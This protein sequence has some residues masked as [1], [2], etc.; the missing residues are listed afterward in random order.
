MTKN[1]PLY[2]DYNS[3]TPLDSRVLEAMIPHMTTYFGNPA[4]QLHAYGW[5]ASL[6]VQKATEQTTKLIHAIP[7][8]IVWNSGATEGNNSV[9]WGVVKTLK[10][11]NPRDKI[12]FITTEIEHASVLKTFEYLKLHENIEYTVLPVNSLGFVSI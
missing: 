3:T 6:A 8:E 9:F 5:A 1:L 7:S 11:Q 12:H 4:N 10:K 2:F